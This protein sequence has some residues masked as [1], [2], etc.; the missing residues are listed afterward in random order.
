MRFP[1][2]LLGAFVY[3]YTGAAYV[4]LGSSLGRSASINLPTMADYPMLGEAFDL[5]GRSVSSAGDVNRDGRSD[6][7]VGAY[8]N[9]LTYL[10]LSGL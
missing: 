1:D 2:L 5:A 9:N 6:L 8:S 3:A 4:V 10:N 7:L